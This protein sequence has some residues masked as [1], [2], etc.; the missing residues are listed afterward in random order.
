VTFTL[1]VAVLY[2]A[3]SVTAF[4]LYGV[5]KRAARGR[6]RRIPERTLHLVAFAGGWPGALAAQ[7]TFRHKTRKRRFQVIF[8]SG[9]LLNCA[10]LAA[11][12]RWA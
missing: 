11:I 2:L 8:W 4:T 12:V 1:A 3:L 7:R 9:V 10:A 5:D 6:R